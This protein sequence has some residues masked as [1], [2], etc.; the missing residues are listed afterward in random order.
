MN[1]VVEAFGDLLE[2]RAGFT[3]A[4]APAGGH[5]GPLTHPAEVLPIL[6]AAAVGRPPPG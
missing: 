3:Q 2:V 5:M 4:V 6:A 1:P